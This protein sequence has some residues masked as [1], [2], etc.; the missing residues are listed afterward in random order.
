MNYSVWFKEPFRIIQ[1]FSWIFLILS[2]WV[3]GYGFFMLK[4][5]GK[6]DGTF[7]NTTELIKTGIYKYIR[8]PLY[9]SLFLVGLGAY[10]KDTATCQTILL[11]INVVSI[12]VT[13][14]IEESEMIL[15]FGREY[16]DYMK[17]S[18]MFIPYI[19]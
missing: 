10:L 12:F 1:I 5:R 17:R 6:P 9:L 8:H 15:K 13:A 4:F 18:K 16:E 11:A 14:R 19:F 2:I 7:E 3:A